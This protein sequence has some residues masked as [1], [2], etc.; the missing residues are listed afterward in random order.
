MK[1]IYEAPSIYGRKGV[2][3]L[4]S[5]IKKIAEKERKRDRADAFAARYAK[6]LGLT[7]KEFKDQ[8][9]MTHL[10]KMMDGKF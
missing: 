3:S 6:E 9:G 7:L 8:G 5:S 10:Q 4:S 1:T 2:L